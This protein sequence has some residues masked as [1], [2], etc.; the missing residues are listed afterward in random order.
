MR[1]IENFHQASEALNGFIHPPTTKRRYNLARMRALMAYLGNP[2]NKLRIIHVAGTSGK[3]STAY[4]IAA[5]LQAAGYTAGLT[6]SPH[7]DEVNERAQINL[8]GLPEPEYC[9]ELSHFLELIDS[10]HTD[11]SYFEVLVA[12]AYWLFHARHVEYAVVEVG[13]GGLLDGTNVIDRSDKL[14]VITDIGLDHTEILGHTLGEI[15]FQKAGIIGMNNATFMHRQ[16]TM[17]MEV[18]QQ[19]CEKN[20]APLYI[21]EQTGEST[22]KLFQSLPLFQQRNLT[23]AIEATNYLLQRDASTSLTA[24]HIRTAAHTLIPARMETVIF[25]GKTLILDGSHN[26]QKIQALVRSMQARFPTEKIALLVSF[27]TTKYP[28]VGRSLK[29]LRNLSS[30]LI[31]TRFDNEG[32]DHY[33]SSIDPYELEKI[34]KRLKFKTVIVESSPGTALSILYKRPETIGLI[35]GSFYLLN[36]IRALVFKDV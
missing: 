29:W 9:R 19:V 6:V 16:G 13:L 30:T 32:G 26:E 36:D 15:A 33:H 23:L 2:Q 5:L 27:G 7:I 22:N 4:Y 1:V 18:I 25:R 21:I 3:T 24:S 12:F 20:K 31:L 35:T 17:V 28:D 14:C 11:P 10:S 34:A 8:V